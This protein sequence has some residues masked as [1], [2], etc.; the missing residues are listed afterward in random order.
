MCTQWYQRIRVVLNFFQTLTDIGAVVRSVVDIVKVTES[1]TCG[2]HTTTHMYYVA[3]TLA[4]CD[5]S[6]RPISNV[7]VK[8]ISILSASLRP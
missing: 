3:C 8:I 1:G 2:I 4:L 7:K 6:R 5:F